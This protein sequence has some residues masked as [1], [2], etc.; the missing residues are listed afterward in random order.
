MPTKPPV[1]YT[2]TIRRDQLKE[3]RE[4]QRAGLP[5]VAGSEVDILD[6]G[7]LDQEP[8]LLAE[9][10]RE[11]FR[12]FNGPHPLPPAESGFE[13]YTALIHADPST[14]LFASYDPDFI[15][16]ELEKIGDI[17]L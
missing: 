11:C 6:D 8:E 14:P 4:L 3:I 10:P 17:H 5:I 12:I 9:L 15:A 13:P 7:S 16:T 1:A 2:R